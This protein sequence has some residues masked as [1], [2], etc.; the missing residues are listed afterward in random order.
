MFFQEEV[1]T[2][3]QPCLKTVQF[4]FLKPPKRTVV[5]WLTVIANL[6]AILASGIRIFASVGP[7][8]YV[9]PMVEF[10]RTTPFI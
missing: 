5:L 1:K 2:L 9:Q 6:L 10:F 4:K 8:R 3:H 7:D